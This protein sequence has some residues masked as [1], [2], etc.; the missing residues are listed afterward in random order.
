MNKKVYLFAAVAA[1]FAACSNNDGAESAEKA[2][3]QQNAQQIAVAFDTYT[4]RGVTRA[5]YAGE[6]TTST[7]TYNLQTEGFGVFAYYTNNTS[8]DDTSIPNFMYNQKVSTASW[9]YEPVKYWPNEYGTTAVADETDK[10]TFFAYAPYVK[11]TPSTGKVVVEAPATSEIQTWGITGLTKNTAAGDPLVKYI[12]NF[13]AL[14]SVDLCWGTV[15]ND[16]SYTSWAKVNGGTQ[17]LTAGK[18]WLDVERPADA[19]GVDQKVK[20]DFKHATS[21]LNVQIAYY[22]DKQTNTETEEIDADKTKI[23]VRSITFKGIA[24]KGALNLNNTDAGKALWMSYNGNDDLESGESVTIYDG[25]KD[26]K[27]GV[28]GATATNEKITGLNSQIIQGDAATS[29]VTK[30][31]QNL[32]TGAEAS[33]PIYVIPTGETVEVEIVYDVETIDDNLSGYL[34]DGKTHGSTIENRIKK[35]ITFGSSDTTFENGK[36]YT[37]KL[38]L[39]MNSVKF[40]AEVTAWPTTADEGSGDLPANK[41]S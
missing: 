8:Y 29:G 24:T 28:S 3:A 35:A 15:A 30:T 13:D 23:Y 20:F 12:V 25:R 18:P 31:L 4:Q 40:D 16:A 7:G 27:E 9:T 14:K 33:T 10:L 36:A 11:V 41:N 38:Y 6:M 17:S 2:Q 26:G 1:L 19:T 37:L 21:K 32:F 34:S 39:G 22:A 5:G